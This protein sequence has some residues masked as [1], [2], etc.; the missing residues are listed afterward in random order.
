VHNKTSFNPKFSLESKRLPR[1]K[2][3]PCM[4]CTAKCCFEYDVWV[5]AHD[6]Y[7]I[8]KNYNLSPEKFIRLGIPKPERDNV[9]IMGKL[10][11]LRLIHSNDRGDASCIFLLSIGGEYRCGINQYKPGVCTNYPFIWRGDKIVEEDRGKCPTEWGPLPTETYEF[12]KKIMASGKIE[13]DFYSKIIEEWN[14]NCGDDQSVENFY[15]YL[16]S[17]VEKFEKL[18]NQ[19]NT[20]PSVT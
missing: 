1:E 11:R 20:P 18:R 13:W 8:Y 4:E 12:L 16:F 2:K 10:V 6:I 19:P 14:K 7:R 9:K 3:I 15:N 17:E 5:N